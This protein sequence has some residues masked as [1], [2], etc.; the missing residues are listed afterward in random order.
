MSDGTRGPIFLDMT[1]GRIRIA[2]ADDHPLVRTGLAAI[3]QSDPDF[4]VVAEADDG[5]EAVEI[6]RAHRPDVMVMDL[7]MPRLDGATA[8]R[9]I[10]Q[11]F[12]EARIIILTSY[13]GDEDIYR[14]LQA[15]ARG[16]LLKDA[17]RAEL[18]QV[19]R[20]VFRG[21]RV[22]PPPVAARLADHTPRIPLTRRELEVLELVASGHSNAEIALAIHRTEGTVKVHMGS[23]LRKLRA[24]DRTAAVTIALRR[25]FI[26]LP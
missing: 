25:G 14:A 24:P 21:N 6:Y 22:I 8:T 13:D 20:T 15:G 2:T 1:E 26:R 23:I 17:I 12:P 16:Y 4:E 5:V 3:L 18:L 11:E 10:L 19:V 9:Q 7:R